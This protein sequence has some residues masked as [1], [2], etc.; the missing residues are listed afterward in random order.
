MSLKELQDSVA[1]DAALHLPD[2][3]YDSNSS[4]HDVKFESLLLSSLLDEDEADVA[5]IRITTDRQD[6]QK[7][8]HAPYMFT[9][10]SRSQLLSLFGTREKWFSLVS[11]DRQVD[12]LNARLHAFSSYRIRTMRAVD[13]DFPVRIVRGL[14]SS[15]YAEIKNTEIMDAIVSKAHPDSKILRLHSGITDR[16][17]YAYV[18]A[19]TPITIPGTTFFGYPG[20]VVKNSEVGYTSLWVIPTLVMKHH[21]APIVLESKHVLKRIH[22]GKTDL[23]EAFEAAFSACAVVWADMTTRIPQLASKTYGNEADALAALERL[24]EGAGSKR[25]LIARST[26][27]YKAKLRT[28]TALDIFEAIVEACAETIDRDEVYDAGAIAGTVLYKLL[29]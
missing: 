17:F 1:A 5:G 16:A 24:L 6:P 29:F 15:E 22:R 11:L 19:P 28:H 2:I 26:A 21:G 7:L 8:H 4:D 13:D 27:A 20:A 3:Y 9:R 10:W 14:V 12:E 23:N 18:M 25:D